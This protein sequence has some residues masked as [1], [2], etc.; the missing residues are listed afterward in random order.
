[1]LL[2]F[3]RMTED[4]WAETDNAILQCLRERG[5]MSPV[6]LAH[7]LGISPGESTTLVCLLAAQGKVKVRLVELD[8]GKEP[9]ASLPARSRRERVRPPARALEPAGVSKR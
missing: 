3:S 5:A 7:R 4:F 6:D 9:G 2:P 1:M 8:E